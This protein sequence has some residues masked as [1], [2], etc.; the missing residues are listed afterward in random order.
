MKWDLFC[1]VVD[2][3]GDI[4]VCWRLA[5][6]LAERGEQVRL[7]VDDAS[8]LAWMAP[9]GASGVSVQPWPAADAAVTPADVVIEAFG[10]ELPPNVAGA[11][12]SQVR[13]PV[14][15]NLE[16]LSAEAYVERSHCLPSPQLGGLGAGLVKWFFYPGFTAATGGLIRERDLLRRQ[17]VFD[18]GA[19]L[20][21]QGVQRRGSERIVSLF[22]YT[23]PTLPDMLSDLA[24][25]P[26]L[27]LVTEGLAA[28]QVAAMLGPDHRHDGLRAVMLPRLAQTD[29][30]HLLWASDLNFVRGEDSWVRAQWAARPFVWQ[31]YPQDD[32]AHAG[33][34]EAFLD[35]LTA[36]APDDL[37][38]P[39]RAVWRR[40]NGLPAASARLPA[41]PVWQQ[42]TLAWRD[43]LLAQA[44]LGTQ[45]IGFAA[46]KG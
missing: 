11:M 2:N 5:V 17:A 21:S 24:Q 32:G 26:T 14:W 3:L 9:H 30:D 22:C 40:W 12:A 42:H 29:Y 44:D 15:I 8:A 41:W 16:Y 33:K 13:P 36:A 4:G 43:K 35:R 10:C 45:L 7:F 39:V 34:V 1:R 38:A 46:E 19:W 6:D 27:L 20:A 25:Q 23:N 18:A 28:Q 37:A 31:A